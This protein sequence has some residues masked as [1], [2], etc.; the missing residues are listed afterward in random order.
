MLSGLDQTQPGDGES[1]AN[2]DS[3][4]GDELSRSVLNSSV[5]VDR[6]NDAVSKY[7]LSLVSCISLT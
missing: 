7:K 4:W 5:P 3:L 2:G 6:L 1:W